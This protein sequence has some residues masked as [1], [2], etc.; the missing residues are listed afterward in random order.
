MTLLLALA[1]SSLPAEANDFKS[2]DDVLAQFSDEPDVTEVQAMVLDYSKTHPKY[3]ESW[4]KAA[5]SAAALPSLTLYYNYK[6][7]F[8]TDYGYYTPEE[9]SDDVAEDND[10]LSEDEA[11]DLAFG[12]FE[13]AQGVDVYHVGAVRATWQLDELVMSSN[14]IRIINEAQDIV[15]L[16]D[17]LLEEATRLYF[18]RRRLQVDLL[19]GGGSGDVRKK[20]SDQLR[21]AE[22]TAQLDAHT[23]GE[24][25]RKL[26]KQ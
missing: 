11:S 4:M 1:L 16:R 13:T 24:F 17:K 21:L 14:E 23:G 2:A 26:P 15:K 7:S 25:S 18:E 19:L 8:G 9:I 10:A 5:K 6:N 20:V 3:L 22:L 12:P